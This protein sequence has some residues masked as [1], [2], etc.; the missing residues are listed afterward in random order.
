MGRGKIAGIVRDCCR[1]ENADWMRTVGSEDPPVSNKRDEMVERG[2][3]IADREGT[4][5]RVLTV[6][7]EGVWM[8]KIKPKSRKDMMHTRTLTWEQYQKFGYELKFP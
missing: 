7:D 3:M 2:G 8:L 4:L 6:D 1:K 5:F